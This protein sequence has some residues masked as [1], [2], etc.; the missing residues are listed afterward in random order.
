MIVFELYILFFLTLLIGYNEVIRKRC[1]NLATSIFTIFFGVLFVIVPI[2]LHTFFGGAKRLDKGI[3]SVYFVSDHYHLLNFYSFLILSVIFIFSYLIK[4]KTYASSTLDLRIFCDNKVSRRLIYLMPTIGFLIFLFFTH[5]TIS[6][7]LTLG[8]FSWYDNPSSNLFMV[9]ISHYFFA[10]TPIAVLLVSV[11]KKNRRFDY[12]LFTMMLICLIFYSV[13]SLDRKF[14]LYVLSGIVGSYYFKNSFR[15]KISVKLFIGM[16]VIAAF[17]FFSQ[18][19]RDYLLRIMTSGLASVEPFKEEI[20]LWVKRLLVEGDI[21]YFYRASC[22]MIYITIQDGIIS[23]GAMIL[24]NLL[25]FIPSSLTFEVKPEDVAKTFSDL[26]NGGSAMR[27]GN[28]PPGFFGII[29]ASFGL[30]FSMVLMI[31]IPYILNKIDKVIRNP[32]RASGIIMISCFLSLLILALR[33]DDSSAVYFFIFNLMVMHVFRIIS[34][35]NF[36]K[37]PLVS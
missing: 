33:G 29:V 35:I 27:R 11:S 21:S 30:Y 13:I 14:I 5:M 10:L 16:S 1:Y 25:F 37:S 20:W 26:V 23:P 32:F 9:A 2:I 12:F 8:R 22:E 7:L 36:S 24:R 4:P 15:L 28:M 17:L 6:D 3:N 18:F 34:R 31:F 19:F